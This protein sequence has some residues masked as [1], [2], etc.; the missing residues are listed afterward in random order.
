M[1]P[2]QQNLA[3]DE[4]CRPKVET[5]PI[6]L[7]RDCCARGSIPDYVNDLNAMANAEAALKRFDKPTSSLT[8]DYATVRY[9]SELRKLVRA[10]LRKVT[11]WTGDRLPNGKPMLLETHVDASPFEEIK[12][13]RATAKQKAKA[14]L[15]ALG[16]WPPRAERA[17]AEAE[18]GGNL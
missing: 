12:L 15:K 8:R 3:I 7:R 16:K 10:E 14:F 11:V 9:T 5:C 13:V 6:H 17:H 4:I 18:A 1:T 2:D